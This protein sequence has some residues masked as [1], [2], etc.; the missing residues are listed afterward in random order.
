MLYIDCNKEGR[1]AIGT[2]ILK[3]LDMLPAYISAFEKKHMVTRSEEP[4]GLGYYVN[5]K[6]QHI[7][8]KMEKIGHTVYALIKGRYRI[9]D[10]IMDCT[11]YLYVDNQDVDQFNYNISTGADPLEN[12]I[13]KFEGNEYYAM[14]NVFGFEQEYGDVVIAPNNGGLKRVY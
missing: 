13:T 11:T 2:M 8:D 3:K 7:I 6:E 9:G 1:I 5:E 4:Y 12:I 10:D 14:A